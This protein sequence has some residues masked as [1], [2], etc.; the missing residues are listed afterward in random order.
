[1]ALTDRKQRDRLRRFYRKHL[2]AVS[3]L[4]SGGLN[5]DFIENSDSY[6]VVQNREPPAWEAFEM[7]LGNRGDVA[8]SLDRHWAGTPLDG[9]GKRLMSLSKHFEYVEE[10]QEVSSFVYEMF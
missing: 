8:G 2:L 7:R 3:G 10:K 9:M 5:S 1:M 6:Y 4:A